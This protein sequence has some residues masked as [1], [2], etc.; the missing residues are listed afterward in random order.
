MEALARSS[1]V[2]TAFCGSFF[3]TQDCAGPTAVREAATA[4]RPPRAPPPPNPPANILQYTSPPQRTESGVCT[5]W[6]P[7]DETVGSLGSRGA[8]K[9]RWRVLTDRN[10]VVIAAVTFTHDL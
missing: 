1:T 8:L 5:V 2:E 3:D 7:T 9:E 10:N 6:K 4:N